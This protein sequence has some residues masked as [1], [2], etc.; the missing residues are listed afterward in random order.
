MTER[1]TSLE[2]IAETE[3]EA[4]AK[5]E[6][7]LGISRDDFDIE[8]LDEGTKGLWGFGQ[9]QARY[10]LTI[11][12]TVDVAGEPEPP[13]EPDASP[14]DKVAPTLEDDDAE[15]LRITVAT[16]EELLQRMDVTARV[17]AEWG[18][19][20]APDRIRPLKVDIRGDDL[21][22]LI[23]RRGETLSAL[24]YITRLIVG[25]ELRHPVAVIIDIEGYRARRERQLRQ[26][27]RRV[28]SQAVETSRVMT[29][30]PMPA[31]ERRIIH[32]ELRDNPEVETE[33]VGEG[34]R[35][36]VTIIPK[37]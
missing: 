5:G 24:Q 7:E 13:S 11:R 8:I 32:I 9:R 21:S 1:R 27:A 36:K 12:S 19:A 37:T 22:V 6:A 16:L 23:G 33:S 3:E 30:E 29:L 15:A 31:N 35:R 18:Q 4:L 14:A 10:R 2:V 26:L 34:N 20:D 17:D 25:K 28:A